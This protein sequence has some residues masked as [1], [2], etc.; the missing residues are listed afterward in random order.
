[1]ISSLRIERLDFVTEL[2]LRRWARRNFVPGSHRTD[3]DWHPVVVDEM[4]RKDAELAGEASLLTV[5]GS[6]GIMALEPSRHDGAR[7]DQAHGNLAAPRI[8][9]QPA[10]EARS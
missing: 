4:R 3:S 2:R 8:S 7:I 9:R 1:M 6:T 10:S 5:I